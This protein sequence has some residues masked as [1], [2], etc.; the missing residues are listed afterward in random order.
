MT[1]AGVEL[2]RVKIF[3]NG[4]INKSVL[5]MKQI[6]YGN[7]REVEEKHNRFCFFCGTARRSLCKTFM[8]WLSLKLCVSLEP[9]V[10]VTFYF[11]FFFE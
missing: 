10:Y 5:V 2:I 11:F 4:N 6:S 1:F 8:S 9:K 3:V 7:S